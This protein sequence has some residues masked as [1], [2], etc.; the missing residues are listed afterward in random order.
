MP[1]AAGRYHPFNSSAHGSQPAAYGPGQPQRTGPHGAAGRRCLSSVPLRRLG[2]VAGSPEELVAAR[3]GGHLA[4]PL[5]EML[6]LDMF[7]RRTNITPAVD[8][9]ISKREP[10]PANACVRKRAGLSIAGVIYARIFS[11]LGSTSGSPA[12]CAFTR[13]PKIS[14]SSEVPA[15]DSSGGR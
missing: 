14:T 12:T 15:L 5:P 8:S 9:S 2:G 4:P 1:A 6:E 3:C 13:S 7:S 11:P 10:L